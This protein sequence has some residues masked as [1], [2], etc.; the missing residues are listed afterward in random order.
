L[1]RQVPEPAVLVGDGL[2]PWH[3]AEGFDGDPLGVMESGHRLHGPVFRMTVDGFE[4]VIVGTRPGL[5][6]LV[7]AERGNL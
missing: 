2:P 5:T 7:R 6:E 4:T 3:P 1:S